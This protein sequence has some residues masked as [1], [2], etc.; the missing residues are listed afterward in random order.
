MAELCTVKLK[1]TTCFIRLGNLLINAIL[2]LDNCNWRNIQMDLA[3]NGLVPNNC[4]PLISSRLEEKC[5]PDI[6]LSETMP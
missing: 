3:P 6:I 5:F 1:K 2:F 4:F